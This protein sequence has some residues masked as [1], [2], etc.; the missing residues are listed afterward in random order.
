MNFPW[1]NKYYPFY[2]ITLKWSIISGIRKDR[3]LVIPS[4]L[5]PKHKKYMAL[6]VFGKHKITLVF[7]IHY[8]KREL[9]FYVRPVLFS[10][11]MSIGVKLQCGSSL[12]CLSHG[13]P[14]PNVSLYKHSGKETIKFLQIKVFFS[15]HYKEQWVQ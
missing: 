3:S 9:M 1:D 11:K 15:L 2:Y 6:C 7:C 14:I 10:V 5:T 12:V 8:L 13:N 4:M